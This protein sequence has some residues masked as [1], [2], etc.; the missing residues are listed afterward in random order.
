MSPLSR[1]SVLRA[2]GAALFVGL[3]G[4]SNVLDSSAP[5]VNR[6]VLRS[7]TGETEPIRILTTY[8]PRD[9]SAVQSQAFYDAHASGELRIVEQDDGPGFYNI[10]A[11]SQNS[12]SNAFLAYNS[13]KDEAPSYD[14][15]FEFVV[16]ADGSLYSNIG[17]TGEEISIPGDG[18]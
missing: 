2:S 3:A 14:L 8:A 11:E 1:R 18:E 9:E 17:R 5:S 16:Q 6:L 12:G 7:D 10:H 15:Q 4:C 13:H